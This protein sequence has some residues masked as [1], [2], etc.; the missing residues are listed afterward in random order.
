MMTSRLAEFDKPGGTGTGGS[1]AQISSGHARFVAPF[2]AIASQFT[3]APTHELFFGEG[4]GSQD[5]NEAINLIPLT[6]IL[7]E[8][9]LI[10]A[11][12]YLIFTLYWIFGPGL[13]FICVW[14]VFVYFHVLSGG[15]SQP[16]ADVFG[17]LLVG[18]YQIIQPTLA[19]RHPR[20]DVIEAPKAAGAAALGS[21][22]ATFG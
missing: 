16:S 21:P 6:K 8:Y 2:E 14:V 1:S 18:A 19:K 4:P 13:P 15:S 10:T 22:P 9:G 20:L 7:L 17:Y 12:F 5:K 11:T 3:T